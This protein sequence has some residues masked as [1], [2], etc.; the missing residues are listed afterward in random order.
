MGEVVLNSDGDIMPKDMTA[1]E[2]SQTEK[3][4]E[5]SIIAKAILEVVK[6]K[7]PENVGQLAEL[8]YEKLRYPENKIVEEILQ[9]Q[10]KGKLVLKAPHISFSSFR[11]Y[12]SSDESFWFW[13]IILAT[14]S[15]SVLAIL[16]P[17][18]NYPLVF[19]RYILGSALVLFLPGYSFLRAFQPKTKLS[20]LEEL[21]FSIGVSIFFV[22][23]VGLF[24]NFTPWGITTIPI[25]ICL[26]SITI[27]TATIATFR[28]YKNLKES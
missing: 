14:I 9:L 10:D 23:I 28:E 21:L 2:K 4:D 8:V 13:A 24:L 18:N 20:Y 7:H 25:L 15:S 1:E 3:E 17:E 19:A 11:D 5:P 26:S 6:E 12:L 16:I 27:S 22:F